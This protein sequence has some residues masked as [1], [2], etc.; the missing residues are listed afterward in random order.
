MQWCACKVWKASP[1]ELRRKLREK[2]R[3]PSHGKRLVWYPPPNGNARNN[4]KK[5]CCQRQAAKAEVH[6]NF[7]VSC[8]HHFQSFAICIQFAAQVSVGLERKA[9]CLWSSLRYSAVENLHAQR[10]WAIV[11]AV[12]YL[13][14]LFGIF[15]D[16][17]FAVVQW[18]SKKDIVLLI[19][20][21]IGMMPTRLAWCPSFQCITHASP[22]H[23]LRLEDSSYVVCQCKAAI[24][25]FYGQN[26]RFVWTGRLSCSQ[27]SHNVAQCRSGVRA[28][29]AK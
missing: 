10:L 17:S 18:C 1:R 4:Q 27:V 2:D 29:D 20:F 11:C 28:Q 13:W 26:L 19:L 22:A 25:W 3:R 9:M 14:L 15:S 6:E 12:L 7:S 16:V 5:K 24:S 8:W 21:M 23:H